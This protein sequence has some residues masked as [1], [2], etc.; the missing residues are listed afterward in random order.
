M[1]TLNVGRFQ[2]RATPD[3]D[4]LEILGRA[5]PFGD[6]IDLGWDGTETFDPDCQFD[7][8]DNVKLTLDHD[9]V[10]G[11][12][13]VFET[14]DD[15][16]YM[17]GRISRTTEGRDIAEMVRDGALDSLSIGFIPQRDELDAGG[18]THRKQVRLM[19]VA[20]TGLPAYENAKITGQR[21][22]ATDTGK[23]TTMTDDIMRRLDE[24]EQQTR[25]AIGELDKR[26][27]Q[28]APAKLGMQWRTAGDYLKALAA[29]DSDAYEFM[30]Q[31]RDLISS[32]E[33]NN[34]NI[35]VADQIRLVESRRSV[36][37]LFRHEALPASGMTVEYLTLGTN[38]MKVAKQASEGD[39]LTYGG[40]SLASSTATVDTYGGYT[41]LSRQVVERSTSPALSTALR[42]LTIAYSA[43]IESACRTYLASAITGAAANKVTTA[44][45]P[46]A[47]TADQ[48]IDAIIEAAEAID[49]R[50][51]S[52]GT[53]AVSKDVFK[54]MAKITRS[55]SALMDV[56]GQGA[57]TLGSIDLAEI[58]GRMLRIPVQ[59]MPGADA[60]TAAFIDP[61]AMT[62]WESGGPFQ[63][64][65]Q[66]V[67][68]LTAD[69]S[70]YG[71]AA[72][73]TTFPGG[74]TPLGAG[75]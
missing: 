8:L 40:I 10:I 3:G 6:V 56:S 47:M 67:V 66:D 74:I 43:A 15:G 36:A 62:L 11:R 73:G 46:S 22:Q 24:I 71:Y 7:G 52:M 60:D 28:R 4:G 50:G 53:L 64:Q 42:A 41:S 55:G 39:N 49:G 21:K 1:H 32:T 17:T 31:S 69:Y 72:M 65:Q 75:E 16:L 61:E 34:V 59:M 37:T 14:K 44:A 18:V 29:G 51:A 19:E 57:D 5:V 68:G 25:S 35:W 20:I 54:A 63:L 48:W 38:T 13:T 27:A 33:V 58:T 12:A 23:D 30:R 70:V 2:T 45:A 26:M 9:H